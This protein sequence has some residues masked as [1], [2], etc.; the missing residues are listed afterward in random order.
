MGLVGSAPGIMPV[1]YNIEFL[2]LISRESTIPSNPAIWETEPK[3]SIDL[4]VY[5]EA[6]NY[7]PLHFLSI[8][9]TYH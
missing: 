6:S 1:F 5:Y 3:E 9:S 8:V 2:E 7:N 4:D